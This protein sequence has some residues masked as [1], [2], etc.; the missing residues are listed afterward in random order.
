MKITVKGQ[1]ICSSG[2]IPG[3]T[4]QTLAARIEELGGEHTH[5]PREGVDI[6]LAGAR[7]AARKLDRARA[8]GLIVL[9]G[10][11]I[12]AL[13]EAGELEL[14]ADVGALSRDE[15]IS[16]ARALLD[17]PAL[18]AT[19]TAITNLVDQCDQEHLP[20]LLSYLSPQL[21]RWPACVLDEQAPRYDFSLGLFGAGAGDPR[22]MPAE[23]LTECV[24]GEERDAYAICS[25]ISFSPVR[26]GTRLASKLFDN[27]SIA[28]ITTL[29]MGNVLDS[30]VKKASF[31]KKLAST[32][33]LQRV[34]TLVLGRAPDGAMDAL[35]GATSLP[36]LKRIIL[37]QDTTTMTTASRGASLFFGPW[38]SQLTAV[39]ISHPA[40]SATLATSIDELPKLR[41][42]A[43]N[44]PRFHNLDDVDAMARHLIPLLD[45]VDTIHLGVDVYDEP[46]S[47]AI[48]GAFIDVLGHGAIQHLDL[49][50]NHSN[51]WTWRDGAGELFIQK[52]FIDANLQ[53]RIGRITAG[54]NIAPGLITILRDAGFTVD[55]PTTAREAPKEPE[56]TVITSVPDGEDARRRAGQVHVH[57]A[58]M[59]SK[60]CEEA[61]WT[62]VGVVN[63]LEQQLD[64]E[65]FASAVA[66]LREYLKPWPDALR[67]VPTHWWADYTHDR[68]NPKLALAKTFKLEMLGL[69]TDA[70]NT[71]RWLEA[72]ARDANLSSITR[73][74]LRGFEAPK[75]TLTA[76]TSLFDAARPEV[77]ILKGYRDR[78]TEALREK[79]EG[80]GLL[81]TLVE[82]TYDHDG[83]SSDL[84]IFTQPHVRFSIRD[85]EDLRQML[86]ITE[87]DH[88]VSLEVTIDVPYELMSRQY[89]TGLTS[90]PA[91]WQKLRYLAIKT[92][93]HLDDEGL[94]AITSWLADA[95][96]IFVSDQFAN[97]GS[98][99]LPTIRFARAG[100]YARAHGSYLTLWHTLSEDQIADAFSE[101]GC[102]V[103]GI[104]LKYRGYNI[105]TLAALVDSLPEVTRASLRLLAW[106]TEAS[107]EARLPAILDALPRLGILGLVSPRYI[108]RDAR[109]QLLDVLAATPSAS[110]L[111]KLQLIPD[112]GSC[113]TKTNAAELKILAR[114]DGL[115]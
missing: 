47:Y 57:D 9:E 15:L 24:S 59:F 73:V 94:E 17:K 113:Q 102:R 35:L 36:N 75:H 8:L 34:E 78:H 29:D 70:K 74:E 7:V 2:K 45:H 41:T 30:H 66:E 81:P 53:E 5:I 62:L 18:Y 44:S 69:D 82:P 28:H 72:F 91:S 40:H 88:V 80:E 115:A 60:P 10:E 19:W 39:G 76:I 96:P 111:S 109:I 25:A 103:T 89:W 87:L 3:Y 50:M 108:E 110:R 104:R 16:E 71:S 42:L 51:K 22:V 4:K 43:I 98:S 101:V 32:K 58:M 11:A 85:P 27:P 49:S 105:P 37:R 86:T 1:S 106:R 21:A 100:I 64:D 61:W 112:D 67:V 31:Y 99:D 23:W 46:L 20:H 12:D 90:R 77:A 54:E 56:I 107:D 97:H 55:A 93:N 68:D 92:P 65:A 63:G 114:G 79:L 84:D 95:R 13:I 83:G 14:E 33:N 26:L 6:F 52:H 38:A 48:A